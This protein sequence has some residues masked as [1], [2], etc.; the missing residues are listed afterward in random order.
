MPDDSMR[1]RTAIA[2]RESAVATNGVELD[3]DIDIEDG[4]SWTTVAGM[5]DD[6][7]NSR[8]GYGKYRDGKYRRCG[9]VG[10]RTRVKSRK[11]YAII[12]L[13][14]D[15]LIK[16]QRLKVAVLSRSGFLEVAGTWGRINTKA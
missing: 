10:I 11:L 4:Y 13:R 12:G 14:S 7:L 8:L 2:S 15:F 1:T 5:N 16:M 6:S 3:V 9:E